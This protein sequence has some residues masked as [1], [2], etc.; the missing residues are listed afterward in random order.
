[1]KRD[2]NASMLP[3]L[4]KPLKLLGLQLRLARQ[5][6]GWTIAEAAARVVVS[7]TT[8]K[9]MEAGDPRVAMGYWAAVMQQFD[10]LEKVVKATAPTED[11]LGQALRMTLARQ[12]VRKTNEDDLYDF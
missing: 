12:R 1:M 11:T 10:L 4:E 9:R 5:S 2:V 8:Y 3:S 6:R 7:P